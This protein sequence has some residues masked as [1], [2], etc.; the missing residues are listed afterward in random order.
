M[1]KNVFQKA[2]GEFPLVDLR[3]TPSVSHTPSPKNCQILGKF[4]EKEINNRASCTFSLL[5][6]IKNNAFDI[7]LLLLEELIFKPKNF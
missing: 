1:H 6:N 2:V 4:Y 7:L 5:R 3:G